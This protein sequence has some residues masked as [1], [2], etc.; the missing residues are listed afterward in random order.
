LGELSTLDDSLDE[1]KRRNHLYCLFI[2]AEYGPL[3][4]HN[5]VQNPDCVVQYI[6]SICP[7]KDGYYTGF[8]EAGQ[9]GNASGNFDGRRTSEGVASTPMN[10][11]AEKDNSINDHESPSA[12]ESEYV[13]PSLTTIYARGDNIKLNV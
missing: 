9:S 6:R 8:C 3:G 1:S 2:S 13:A 11:Q 5:R 4:K 7:S 12:V 10:A